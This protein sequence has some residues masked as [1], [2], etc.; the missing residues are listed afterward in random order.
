MGPKSLEINQCNLRCRE[1]GN[2][3]FTTTHMILSMTWMPTW[4]HFL[5]VRLEICVKNWVEQN[6][7]PNSQHK[8]H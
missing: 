2:L 6:T 7:R 8:S 5:E 4:Q 3:R 1:H